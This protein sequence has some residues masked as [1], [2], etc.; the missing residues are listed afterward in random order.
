MMTTVFIDRVSTPL[1]DLLLAHAGGHL[2]LLDFAGNE[3][4]FETMLMRRFGNLPFGQRTAPPVI[5]DNL[6]D[7]FDG[8][9]TA[10]RNIPVQARGTSFQQQVWSMLARIPAG[11]VWTYVQL[12]AAIDRPSAQQAVG[13]ANAQNPIAIVLPCHLVVGSDGDLTGYSGGLTRK[14]WLLTHEGARLHVP[15]SRT[16][17]QADLFN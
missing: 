6:L 10:L 13:Q 9:L 16:S 7:Y 14:R 12:A 17:V 1:G 15:E 8:R 5:R 4:R 11:E 3:Q 2:C